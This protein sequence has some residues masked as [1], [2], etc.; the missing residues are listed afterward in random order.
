MERTRARVCDMRYQACEHGYEGG[1]G[2][3]QRWISTALRGTGE[4][5]D[6]SGNALTALQRVKWNNLLAMED[7]WRRRAGVPVVGEAGEAKAQCALST[8]RNLL[9]DEEA[10]VDLLVENQ[11][12]GGVGRHY[13]FPEWRKVMGAAKLVWDGEE[14]VTFHPDQLGGHAELWDVRLMAFAT[15]KPFNHVV[16]VVSGLD[17]GGGGASGCMITTDPS[18]EGDGEE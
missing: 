2:G 18:E 7:V 5:R 4:D 6:M 12:R 15:T 17:G 1:E 16:A 9:R 8:L 13:H 14:V 11:T 10:S 3:E